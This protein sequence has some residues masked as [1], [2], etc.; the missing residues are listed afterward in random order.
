[1]L[2]DIAINPLQC[3]LQVGTDLGLIHRL[4]W[5]CVL[6]QISL[7]ADDAAIFMD[8]LCE[9]ISTLAQ[10]LNNFGNMT[11]LIVN[12]EESLVVPIY[13]NNSDLPSVLHELP[14]PT[15]S[16][17]MKYLGLP[18]TVR[19]LNRFHYQFLKIKR[20]CVLLLGRGN[21]LI[22]LE[23]GLLLS[24]LSPLKPSTR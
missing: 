17:P 22:L 4:P 23:G 13:C 16:L 20:R 24:W 18:L 21:G 19:R 12:F 15:T 10:I 14:A 6:F 11:I 9:Y 8:L 1:M 2:F 7:Y 3:I 5:K